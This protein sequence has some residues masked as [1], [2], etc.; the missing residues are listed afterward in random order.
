M[1]GLAIA[2]MV[3]GILSIPLAC[4]LI[5]IPLAL[6]GL[7]LGIIGLMKINGQ[8]QQF[9]GKGVAIAGIVTSIIGLVAIVP[10]MIAI[11]LPSLGKA[12]EM[13]NRSVC[14]A[15]LRGIAQSMSVY[16][17]GNN[18]AYPVVPFAPYGPSNAG[19]STASVSGSA[20]DALNSMYAAASPVK[21]APLAGP[22]VLVMQGAV[23]PKQFLCKSDPNANTPA[24]V[25]SG[26]AWN[27]DFQSENQLS[28]SFAY[29]YNSAGK[30]GG[31]WRDYTDSTLPIAADMAPLNGTGKPS[32]DVNIAGSDGSSWNSANHQGE[33]ENVGYGDGHAAFTRVPTCG[34]SN[35]NIFTLGTTGKPTETGGTQ[36]GKSPIN[37]PEA[38][39]GFGGRTSTGGSPGN[40]DIILVPARNLDTGSFY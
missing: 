8:P 27:T 25:Q 17:A 18:S 37:I 15:N 35:D 29:P 16:A 23:T 14:A 24:I 31:W 10:L 9:G 4:F 21:G 11:L 6:V 40:Y 12:R 2:S 19:T 20:D 26:T 28:Y 32:H 33:G 3:L 30:V 5:G 22:W 34:Q 38:L 1:S 39:P 13:A 36:P 7:I